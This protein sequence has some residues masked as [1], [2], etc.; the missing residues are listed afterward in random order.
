M[1]CDLYG[2]ARSS[3]ATFEDSAG[4]A[5]DDLLAQ[6]ADSSPSPNQ[7]QGASEAVQSA[8][9]VSPTWESLSPEARS[10]YIR[11]AEAEIDQRRREMIARDFP[12]LAKSIDP[13]MYLEKP[14]GVVL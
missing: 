13:T 12:D 1:E 5:A 7:A 4:L 3:P 10:L 9:R 6:N 2:Y 11:E 8:P 14:A